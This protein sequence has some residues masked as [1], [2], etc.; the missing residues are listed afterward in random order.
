VVSADALQV[1]R[2]LPI[3]TNQPEGPTRL[4]GIR[5]LDEQMT[6]GA[7]AQL[8]HAEIDTL[9]ATTGHAVVTGGTGLYLRAALADLDVPPPV[10]DATLARVTRTVDDDRSA[11]HGRLAS[12]DPAAAEV[13]HPNDRQRLVRALALAESGRS[14]TR[15]DDRLWAAETRRSTLVLGLEVT[16]PELERRIRARAE[17]M[18]ARGVADEV[19]AALD[20]PLSR[21]VEKTLG[22]REIA[23][24]P[25]AEAL[26]RIVVRTRR[27][28]AYQ[29]KWMRRIPGVVLV[30]AERPAAVVAAEILELVGKQDEL[31]S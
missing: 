28:A 20:A 6:V 19:R 5:A 14:V 21:T 1:Y 23:T 30:D 26:E 10:D 3:L 9:V 2:G 8:A 7:F 18:F 25:P 15:A 16:A 27:Y 17:E 24:L 12:L 22:L 31:R 29:R 4:V 13:T 11:A